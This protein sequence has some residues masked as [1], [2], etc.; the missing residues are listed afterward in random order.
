MLKLEN[1][2]ANMKISYNE[3]QN[4]EFKDK[5]NSLKKE[6]PSEYKVLKWIN[7]EIK[8]GEMHIIM[9]PNGSG[10][11]SLASILAGHPKYEVT[12]GKIIF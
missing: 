9:G 12:N 8:P 3:V 10:K 1:L 7:L 11:S 5:K 2:E 4:E 6:F